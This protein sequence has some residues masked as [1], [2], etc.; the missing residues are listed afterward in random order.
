MATR[1]FKSKKE[2]IA[3]S[4]CII[5]VF[6]HSY[7]TLAQSPARTNASTE[8]Q[9]I[10]NLVAQEN[11]GKHVIKFTDDRI[12]VSGA[13]PKPIIG[14]EM[15]TEN[16]QAD[17]RIKTERQNMSSKSRI[18]RLTVAQAG[19]MA[20]EFGYADLSWDTPDK[21][22]VSFEASYLRVWRKFQGEWKVDVFFARP[23]QPV[24]RQ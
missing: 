13:Y 6:I 7:R 9:A 16:Q 1:T 14:K 8:E 20:Y 12:F 10:R 5:L 22:H 21:K 24:V 18:E 23:N 11:Q 4:F 2:I 3:V 15:V 19:D 17:N